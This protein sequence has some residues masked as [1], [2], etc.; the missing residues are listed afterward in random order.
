MLDELALQGM[1]GLAVGYAFDGGDRLAACLHAQ[2]QARAHQTPVD[3]NAAGA[4]VAR[5]A[6]LLGAGEAQLIAQ[7]VE[8]RLVCL[9]QELDGIAI[10]RRRYVMLC[11]QA[12]LARSSAI[13]AARRAS[14]PATLM[15]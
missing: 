6:A 8:Q 12:V 1:Q 3:G 13:C 15:R 10:D 14:T 4:A 5:R 9:A 7:D 2:H 11:H